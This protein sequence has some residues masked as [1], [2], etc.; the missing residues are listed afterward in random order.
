[1]VLGGQDLQHSSDAELLSEAA[2][3]NGEAFAVFYR[4]H[5]P[6]V[7]AFLIRQT[8]G[9]AETAADLAAE[10]FA[11]ALLSCHRYRPEGPSAGPWVIGIARN[12]LLMSL[13]RGRVE[14]KARRRLH[15]DAVTLED[16]DLERVQ[17]VASTGTGRLAEL[18]ADLPPDQRFAVNA[19]VVEER[20]YREIATELQCS[21]LVVRKRVSRGLA[22]VRSQ[23]DEPGS[24]GGFGERMADA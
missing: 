10:V 4:R 1:M 14:S 13:R 8:G 24:G 16:E 22:R 17:A 23:L 6:A 18:V 12:K 9:D 20:T 3:R 21:E 19:H 7:L 15:F 2:A 11:A 5:V